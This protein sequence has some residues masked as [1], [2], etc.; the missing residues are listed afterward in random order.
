MAIKKSGEKSA[1]PTP[2]TGELQSPPLC[3]SQ[4][5]AFGTLCRGMPELYSTLGR[6]GYIPTD[7]QTSWGVLHHP[8]T[9]PVY[10]LLCNCQ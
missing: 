4:W 5:S 6:A 2:V 8:C 7:R 3:T 1:V 10:K 9:V